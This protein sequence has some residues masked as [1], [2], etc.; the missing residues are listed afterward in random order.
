MLT[1]E[2]GTL[3]GAWRAHRRRILTGLALWLVAALA[4]YLGR[5]YLYNV[6]LGPFPL[7]RADALTLANPDQRLE[8]FVTV[9]GDQTELL[10]PRAYSAGQEPYSM[11]GLLSFG[12]KGMLL[13]VPSSHSGTSVTGTLEQLSGFERDHVLAS[14]ARSLTGPREFLPFRLEGTRYFR[15]IGWMLAVVPIAALV[16]LGAFLMLRNVGRS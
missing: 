16:V 5:R 13:R 9:E 4:A 1:S 10:F 12:H 3:L 6:L 2:A 15:T 8:Y 14:R 7:G 11:Y